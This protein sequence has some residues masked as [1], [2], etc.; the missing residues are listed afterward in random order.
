[1]V[2]IT[3]VSVRWN[4]TFSSSFGTS[5]GVRQGGVLSPILFTV[6]ID[7]LLTRLSKLGIGCYSCHL[8]AGSL[9]YADDIA[10]LAPSSSALLILLSVCEKFSDEYDLIFN[11]AKTQLICIRSDKKFFL[12]DGAFCFLG[13]PL[14]FRNSIVYLGHTLLFNLD[15]ADDISCV[16]SDLCRKSYYLLTTFSSC[17]PL[18][19][20]K[21]VDSHCLSL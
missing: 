2:S 7:E 5:N 6:Y 10:L 11:T 16:A 19:K 9:G 17:D 4:R 15:D 20:T 1:M 18:V 14:C 8:F 13:H 21:L 3:N 12:P